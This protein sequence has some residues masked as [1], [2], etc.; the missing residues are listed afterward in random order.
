MGGVLR[1]FVR[2]IGFFEMDKLP[3]TV[4]VIG[5]IK[6]VF[7]IALGGKLH[8]I[9][10]PGGRLLREANSSSSFD[11][12]QAPESPIAKAIPSPFWQ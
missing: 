2:K 12:I 7:P 11:G 10:K 9:G 8:N 3:K 6:V 1:E 4:L 5:L